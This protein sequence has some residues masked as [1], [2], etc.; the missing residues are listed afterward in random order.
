MSS[1]QENS[2]VPETPYWSYGDLGVF[3]VGLAVLTLGLHLLARFHL[4]SSSQ[5]SHPGDG[6]QV[7]IVLYL[8][9]S[10]Y[11]VLKLRYRQAVL[12]PLGW[13]RP[14]LRQAI[15]SLGIG[16][17]L[18]IMAVLYQRAQS[19]AFGITPSLPLVLLAALLA[20]ILEESLF[21]G[22]L[23]PLLASKAG[24]AVAVA[25]TAAV[26]ALFH[27]PTDLV[28]WISFGL[29]GITYGLIRVISDTTTAPAMAHSAYNLVLL[30]A[31]LTGRYL[32]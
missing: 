31:A 19:P 18:G 6:L 32:S 7:A 3:L 22:C 23:F 24:N 14:K 20:P 17:T 1:A 26:F 27:G 15:A 8:T 5:L 21:R 30:S 16:V 4:L 28:H 13:V 2:R 9:V 29:T 12:A 11:A 10:L 25:A